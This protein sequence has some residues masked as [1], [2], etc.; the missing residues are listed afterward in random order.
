MALLDLLIYRDFDDTTDQS[1]NVGDKANKL[2][3]DLE[4]LY[5]VALGPGIHEGRKTVVL[6]HE[7]RPEMMQELK[8]FF[9]SV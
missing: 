3:S 9:A 1:L 7:H 4:G 5:V 8:A 2:G 6:A